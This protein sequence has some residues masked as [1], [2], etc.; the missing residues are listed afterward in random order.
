MLTENILPPAMLWLPA[1]HLFGMGA[2]N[3]AA[4]VGASGKIGCPICLWP[5]CIGTMAVDQLCAGDSDRG[6]IRAQKEGIVQHVFQAQT[7]Q[8]GVAHIPHVH[9]APVLVFPQFVELHRTRNVQAFRSG[10]TTKVG[11]RQSV[12]DP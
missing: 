1:K 3:K 4:T 7:T 9:I 12:T 10:Y 6:V 5:G 8:G 11:R 2:V